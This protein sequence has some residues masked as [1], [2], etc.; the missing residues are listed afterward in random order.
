VAYW[1]LLALFLMN[2]LNYIDRFILAAVLGPIKDSLGLAGHEGGWLGD[3]VAGAFGSVFYIS[4]ALFSPVV[5]WLGDR[6]PR[7]YLLALGVGI[8]SVATFAT[9]LCTSFEQMLVARGALGIGEATY[10]ILAPTLIA[11]LFHRERRNF[12]I[13]FFYLAVPF[14]AAFGYGLGG[15][16][17]VLYGWRAAF[18]IVGLPGLA[19]AVAALFLPEPR[20]GATEARATGE[21]PVVLPL[22]WS[23][24]ASL[25]RNRSYLLNCLGMAM[26]AFALGGLQH[27]APYFFI[28][29]RNLPPDTT[30]LWLGGVI[31][32]AGLVGTFFG[33]WLAD[34]LRPR[35]SGVLRGLRPDAVRLSSIHPQRPDRPRALRHL[36]QFADRADAGDDEHRAVEHDPDQRS[37]AADPRRGMA[38]NLFLLH[39]LGDIPSPLLIGLT[40]GLTGSWLW[41]MAITLPAVVLGGAFFCLGTPYLERDQQASIRISDPESPRG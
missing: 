18:F 41:G 23:V 26:F 2:L 12:A 29:T 28:R 40:V 19:V 17:E 1:T 3:T 10:A 14:G 20:R 36:W 30:N 9:G 5:G 22:S 38:V 4:Y 11:D 8:W 33:G 16:I 32:V 37:A 13:T 6:A 31:A 24:Y 21:H 7:R 15:L 27:W 34:R 35:W 25:L 39:F